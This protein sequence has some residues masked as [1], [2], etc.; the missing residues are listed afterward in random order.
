M[1]IEVLKLKR[2]QNISGWNSVYIAGKIIERIDQFCQIMKSFQVN[3]LLKI[4]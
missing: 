2:L 1:I 3:M 4:N